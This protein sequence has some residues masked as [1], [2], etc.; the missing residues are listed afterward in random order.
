MQLPVCKEHHV[1]L[2]KTRS[3][4]TWNC[5]IFRTGHGGGCGGREGGGRPIILQ[6]SKLSSLSSSVIRKNVKL[7]Q[8]N[9]Q[10]LTQADAHVQ[11]QSHRLH[12]REWKPTY[13]TR[14]FMNAIP[15]LVQ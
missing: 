14:Q 1:V 5:V 2:K 9:G 11:P 13:Y 8:F 12:S 15:L 10:Q 6:V 4:S 7:C 3:W